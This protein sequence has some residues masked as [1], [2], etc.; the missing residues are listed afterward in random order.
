MPKVLA[1]PA[2]QT[3]I[4]RP[5]PRLFPVTGQSCIHDVV[6]EMEAGADARDPRRVTAILLAV[7]EQSLLASGSGGQWTTDPDASPAM[8]PFV[9][10][11]AKRSA[12]GVSST[13]F[14]AVA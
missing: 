14:L 2:E 6:I 9:S 11:D 7:S 3:P 5:R 1:S 8:G 13:R 4:A 12:A 10:G